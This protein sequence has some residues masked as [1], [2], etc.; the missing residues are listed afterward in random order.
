MNKIKHR[1][2]CLFP[3]FILFYAF[4]LPVSALDMNYIAIPQESYAA[5]VFFQ[6]SGFSLMDSQ[7]QDTDVTSFTGDISGCIT[8]PTY[9]LDS[10]STMGIQ[11]WSSEAHT[12]T[13]DVCPTDV[14]NVQI[15]STEYQRVYYTRPQ[16]S[17][18]NYTPTGSYNSSRSILVHPNTRY[19]LAF[20]VRGS[21]LGSGDYAFHVYGSDLDNITSRYVFVSSVSNTY[22]YR[23]EVSYGSGN[24][25]YVSIDLPKHFKNAIITPLWAGNDFQLTDDIR[26][27]IGLGSDN[28]L[29]SLLENGNQQSQDAEQRLAASGQTLEDNTDDLYTYEDDFSDDLNVYLNGI[30][31]STDLNT[32]SGFTNS[33][34]WVVSQFNSLIAPVQITSYITFILVFGIAVYL[35]GMR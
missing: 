27:L 1:L 8:V 35:I 22:F 28:A 26:G 10:T 9:V 34:G 24:A 11:Q 5:Y 2:K 14:N 30:D 20:G 33:L 29:K 23:I 18:P 16:L 25:K 3:C 17:N 12:N 21:Y 31:T 4:I 32:L 19:Y 7:I 6:N 13:F 15:T